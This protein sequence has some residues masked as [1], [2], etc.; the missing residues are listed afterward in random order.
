VATTCESGP[1]C[2]Q[3]KSAAFSGWIDAEGGHPQPLD[4]LPG[5]LA[6]AWGRLP[7]DLRDALGAMIAHALEGDDDGP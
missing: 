4:D 7:V 2:A 6:E 1:R 3:Q 5:R